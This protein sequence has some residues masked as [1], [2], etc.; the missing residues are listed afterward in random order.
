MDVQ[1]SG[2]RLGDPGLLEL[3]WSSQIPSGDL[4]SNPQIHRMGGERSPASVRIARHLCIFIYCEYKLFAQKS[5]AFAEQSQ[6]CREHPPPTPV[7][8]LLAADKAVVICLNEVS[9]IRPLLSVRFYGLL[10]FPPSQVLFLSQGPLQETSLHLTVTP[11]RP[12]LISAASS[13]SPCC[14]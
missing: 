13:D 1:V 6:G 11:P 12:L 5:C 14:V 4:G 8:F 2:P 10:G 3:E 9:G 7:P